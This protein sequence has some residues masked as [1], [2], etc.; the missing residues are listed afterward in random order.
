M[1]ANKAYVDNATLDGVQ[2]QEF[3]VP[4]SGGSGTGQAMDW[5]L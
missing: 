1:Q 2:A 4:L 5:Y 3:T